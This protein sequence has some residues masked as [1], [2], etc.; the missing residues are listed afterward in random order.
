MNNPDPNDPLARGSAGRKA[1]LIAAEEQRQRSKPR[2]PQARVQQIPAHPRRWAPPP[3]P[4]PTEEP[5][6]ADKWA[7]LDA[8]CHTGFITYPGTPSAVLKSL[9]DQGFMVKGIGYSYVITRLGRLEATD[10]DAPV[11]PKRMRGF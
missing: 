6:F 1:A 5:P 3:L 9:I 2:G 7:L 8:A 10:V 4:S 11:S